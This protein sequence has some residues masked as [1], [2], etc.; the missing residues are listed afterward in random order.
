RRLAL[1]LLE[2]PKPVTQF[3]RQQSQSPLKH[4]FLSL[5]L[6]LEAPSLHLRLFYSLFH[7][8]LKCVRGIGYTE[9]SEM[10]NTG[11]KCHLSVSA[12]DKSRLSKADTGLKLITLFKKRSGSRISQTMRRKLN[13][14]SH[15]RT[16]SSV[17][18][19]RKTPEFLAKNINNSIE[20]R[21]VRRKLSKEVSDSDNEKPLSV[22][23]QGIK[24]SS[25][26]YKVYEKNTDEQVKAVQIKRR[27]KRRKRR[28]N[29]ELDEP[30]RLQRRT[31]YLL[32]KIKLEQNLIDA[33]SGEGW[34]GQSREKIKPEKELQ[35]AKKQ[36]VKCKIGIRDAIH[37]LESLSSDACIED[38]VIGP[39]GTVS[40]E[41]IFCAKCKL[42]EAYPDN[43]IIL[44]DGT[45]N[46]AF[47][48]KCL[49]PPLSTENI[50]PEDQGWYCK[51]CECK[52][53]ILEVV[54]A[55]LGT[56]FSPN[57]N[58]QDVF[59]EEAVTPDC[60]NQ[61][62]PEEEWPS[63]ESDDDDYDPERN[64]NNFSFSRTNTE[65]EM[66]GYAS[67]SSWTSEKEATLHSGRLGNDGISNGKF[68]SDKCRSGDDDKVNFL[69]SFN[70]LDSDD[71]TDHIT[72]YRRQRRDVDYKKLYDVSM[73]KL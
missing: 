60:K 5:S 9:I 47:H 4:L 67:S 19:K 44:C 2:N 65:E 27:R 26:S 11:N 41:H 30:S 45:C 33:Y 35:R 72:D 31:R 28:R 42:R 13:A 63:D 15:V 34:K 16:L 57:S 17:L 39:D 1:L 24:S 14:R 37:Q 22:I 6:S 61:L 58:W 46:C 20:G 56:Q 48:Q 53:E 25:L 32:I 52:M 71:T 8:I 54:N 68:Y 55:H 50:P 12:A 69:S 73:Y 64:E 21:S 10:V 7:Y 36:I 40:H 66:S 18:S 62:N 3:R 59:K 70:N 38:S 49:E 43:D 23:L 29:A 51:F